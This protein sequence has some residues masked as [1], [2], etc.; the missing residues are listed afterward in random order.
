MLVHTKKYKLLILCLCFTMLTFCKT[1]STGSSRVISAYAVRGTYN[2]CVNYKSN[3]DD[4]SE[5]ELEYYRQV[6]ISQDQIDVELENKD[7]DQAIKAEYTFGNGCQK[8]RYLG[9]C[10]LSMHE[11]KIIKTIYL[12]ED[13]SSLCTDKNGEW[14]NLNN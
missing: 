9:A 10:R 5:K 1:S 2:W 12:H 11:N 7:L 4:I 13:K 8:D 6:S 3:S 14:I